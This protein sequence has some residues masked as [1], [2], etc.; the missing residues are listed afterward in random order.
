VTLNS[1][2]RLPLATVALARIKKARTFGAGLKAV[3]GF[4]SNLAVNFLD[5]LFEIVFLGFDDAE[6]ALRVLH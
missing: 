6:F 2:R 3:V 1:V 4:S 5:D